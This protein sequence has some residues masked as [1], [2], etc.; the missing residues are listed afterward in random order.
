MVALAA[1]AVVAGAMVSGAASALPVKAVRA[2]PVPAKA[3]VRWSTCVPR[4]VKALGVYRIDNDLFAGDPGPSCIRSAG[5]SF[6]ITRNYEPD[7]WGTVTA[8]PDVRVGPAYGYGDRKSGL[9]VRVDSARDNLVL[10]VTDTGTARGNWLQDTDA[11][12]FRTR[13]VSGHG[14]TE[15]LV[16]AD[17]RDQPMHAARAPWRKA[18]IAGRSWWLSSWVDCY[19]SMC[20]RLIIYRAPRPLHEMTLPVEAFQKYAIREH[21]LPR[22]DYVAS[23]AAGAE[24]WYGCKGLSVGLRVTG[25]TS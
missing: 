10:H 23:Y 2:Q 8:Y 20:W 9:P 16:E 18:R 6:T 12:Y 25:L 4:K 13:H 7:A 22:K 3:P 17:W 24:C 19:G 1:A 14:S 21:L 15:M 11:W 5:T